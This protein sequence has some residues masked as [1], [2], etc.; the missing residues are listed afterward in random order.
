[1]LSWRINKEL[2]FLLMFVDLD[3]VGNSNT[4]ER[5]DLLEKFDEVFGFDRIKSL[6]A[7]REFIG[8]EWFFVLCQSRTPFFIR[9]K[10]NIRVPYGDKP[11]SVKHLFSHLRQG[12]S[13]LIEKEMYGRFSLQERTAKRTAS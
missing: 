10:E 2:S 4:G 9:M 12:K 1:M 5:L 7:D 3:K 8:K 6:L 11:L 13:R